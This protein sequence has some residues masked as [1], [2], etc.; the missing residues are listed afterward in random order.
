M[1]ISSRNFEIL[2]CL[3]I[4]IFLVI[5][6]FDTKAACQNCD[7]VIENWICLLCYKTCCSRYIQEHMLFHHIETEHAL[8]LSYSDLSVW[9]FKCENYIDNPILYKYK[10]L[11][12]R[13]KFGEDMVWSYD[14]QPILLDVAASSS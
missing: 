11:A 14:Q 13:D 3:K 5:T 6:A 10:N 4:N 1:P 12:H 2:V 9:C 7:T 8:A